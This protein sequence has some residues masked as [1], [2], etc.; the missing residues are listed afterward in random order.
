MLIPIGTDVHHKRYPTVTY[1]LIGLNLLIFA[2]QWSIERSGGADSISE[3]SRVIA[4][5]LS[6]AQLSQGNFH[7]YSLFT[8]QFLHGGWWHLLGNMLFLLPFGKAVEDR[9]GHIGFA[10]FY[11][12]CGAFGGEIHTVL[13]QSPVIGASGSV[14]AVTAAFIVLAPKTKIKVLLIFFIIGVYQ[15]P[16]MLLVTFFVLFD[17]FSLLASF[18]GANAQPTAWVVHLG[19][20]ASG[21]A[22]TF[23][24]LG[25]GIIA[26]SEFDLT[27]MFK[28]AKRR[29]E[30]R[31]VIAQNKTNRIETSN[32]ATPAE[33]LRA[34]LS[35][36]VARGDEL[37]AADTYL[38][39]INTLPSL[40]LNKQTHLA[41]ANALI[42]DG[43]IED[44]VLLYEKYL[45]EHKNAKDCGE[46]AL[47]LCAKYIRNLDNFKRA[48]ILLK[49]FNSKITDK[50][51]PFAARLE[52][53]MHHDS[54]T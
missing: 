12:L 8:Y 52:N 15:I 2:V 20:Y 14:C 32:T 4:D 3:S 6:N 45:L 11:L 31:Q 54:T 49:Q 43:R 29:R 26:S 33:L 47:L 22:I 40:T 7:F 10:L 53:E 1:L 16:S 21:F 19:G 38:K 44:G 51:K 37:Q 23:A 24:L 9:M 35:D 17:V 5:A 34:K 50:H 46:V 36:S 27:Q 25:L 39:E 42:I 30:Y 41:I 13:S 18:A 48:K 28:Q